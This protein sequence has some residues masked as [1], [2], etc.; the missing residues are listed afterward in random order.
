MEYLEERSWG[1]RRW[2]QSTYRLCVSLIIIYLFFLF[3]L[4]N[5]YKL[6]SNVPHPEKYVV[7]TLSFYSGSLS[8]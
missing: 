5:S 6:V 1:L 4:L 3:F 7:S 2:E 8:Y